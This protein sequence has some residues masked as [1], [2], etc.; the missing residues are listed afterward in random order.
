MKYISPK[1]MLNLTIKRKAAENSPKVAAKK[2]RVER[3]VIKPPS[4]WGDYTS[5]SSRS[6]SLESIKENWKRPRRAEKNVLDEQKKIN[7]SLAKELK[8]ERQERTMAEKQMR[9]VEE[10]AKITGWRE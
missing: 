10:W 3:K 1:G 2:L 6:K 7:I 4:S 9:G 5:E 8:L